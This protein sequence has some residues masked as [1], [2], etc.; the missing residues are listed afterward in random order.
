MAA[1]SA[2]VIAFTST[3]RARRRWCRFAISTPLPAA[4]FRLFG[5]ARQ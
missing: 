1:N 3:T 4:G 2:W 5:L